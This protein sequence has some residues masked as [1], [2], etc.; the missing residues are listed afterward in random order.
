MTTV[1]DPGYAD[2]LAARRALMV[3]EQLV[4]RGI[5][6]PR[7]LQAMRDVP[8]HEFLP[9]GLLA[10]AY[11]DRPLPIGEGQTISQP[12]MV[13]AMTEALAVSASDRILDVGTGS[14]YQAA[15]LARL[16]Q[17]VVSIERHP[18][19][20]ARA[21]ATAARL[22]VTNLVV[23]EGDGSEGVP[24]FSPYDAIL[25]AAGAPS[26]PPGLV[27]QL[28]A[29]GRLVIPVGP[30][31]MQRVTIVTRDGDRVGEETREGCVF[32]PLVGRQ[33]WGAP[34]K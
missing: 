6:D 15:V 17:R 31:D 5:R 24:V 2:A 22:G 1:R 19:L 20:A 25:V 26:V 34:P 9:D 11:E 33:G 29:G 16:G 32:V 10:Q 12:Y 14:G 27:A 30:A 4:S 3:S 18:A 21:R 7:V 23:L 13:A 28:A 8:R